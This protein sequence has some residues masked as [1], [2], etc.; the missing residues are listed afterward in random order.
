[1]CM[2]IWLVLNWVVFGFVLPEPPRGPVNLMWNLWALGM[3][4]SE[5]RHGREDSE[6]WT[7]LAGRVPGLGPG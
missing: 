6:V 2:I 5:E 4:D 7:F 1:M 3:T